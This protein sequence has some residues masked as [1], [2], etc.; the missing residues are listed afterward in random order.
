MGR[1]WFSLANLDPAAIL[2]GADEAR[3]V[4]DN[5]L[6]RQL[7]RL[8]LDDCDLAL[9]GFSQGAMMALHVGLRRQKPCA[10]IACFSGVLVGADRLA[11]EIRARPPVLLVHGDRD[12]VVPAGALAS[13]ESAL[14][15]QGIEVESYL[16]PGL[17]HGID[18]LGMEF[19]GRFLDRALNGI[20]RDAN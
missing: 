16:R 14:K 3:P 19:G 7:A 12:E 4:I 9:V 17:G 6:D 8:G 13:T 5:F 15:E 2:T 18:D 20:E 1:Q 11:A 10:A